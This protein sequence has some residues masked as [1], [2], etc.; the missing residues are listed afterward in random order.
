M[1]KQDLQKAISLADKA[2]NGMASLAVVLRIAQQSKFQFELDN[3]DYEPPGEDEELPKLAQRLKENLKE[4]L[5]LVNLDLELSDGLKEN[6]LELLQNLMQ[7][8]NFRIPLTTIS[9]KES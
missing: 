3:P 1:S 9:S 5:L 8:Q 2:P 4:K 6:K 7:E